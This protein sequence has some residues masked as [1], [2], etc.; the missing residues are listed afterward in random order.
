MKFDELDA[1]IRVFEIDHCHFVLPGI[2]ILTR[3]DGDAL[4]PSN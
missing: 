1:K 2:Y 4:Q 3:I